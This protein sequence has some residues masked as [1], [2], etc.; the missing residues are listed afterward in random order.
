[1]IELR[2]TAKALLKTAQTNQITFEVHQA[3]KLIIG[4]Q[5]FDVDGVTK[6][7]QQHQESNE[8][9]ERMLAELRQFSIESEIRFNMRQAEIRQMIDRLFNQGETE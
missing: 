4:Q 6:S 3:H 8:R 5:N 7:E 1:M 2:E 9:F